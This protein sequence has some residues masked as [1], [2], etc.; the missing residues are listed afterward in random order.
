[1]ATEATTGDAGGNG[2]RPGLPVQPRFPGTEARAGKFPGPSLIPALTAIQRRCGWLPREE[3]V[4]LSRDVRRPLYE[5]EGIISF[6]P[7][8]R[9][10]PPKTV[11]LAVCHDLTCWL[12]GSDE[13]IRETKEKYGDDVEIEIVEVSCLGRCDIA[14]AAAVDERPIALSDADQI[15]ADARGGTHGRTA[16]ERSDE[17]RPNDPYEPGAERYRVF[18]RA[19]AGELAGEDIVQT[20]KDS[21]LRGM[22]GAGFP[23]G[24]KWEMVAAQQAQPKYAICNADESEPGTFKDRQILAEQPHL[25]LEG[26]LLG[27]VVTGCEEGW[28]FIRHEYGPEE[29]VLREEI[30]A[31]RAQG[32]LGED[33][34]GSGRTF[35]IEIFTSPGGYILGEE[36]ALLECMEGHRGEPRNKPP[37]P[38]IYGLWGKPTLMNSVETF[39]SVPII[40]EN[41]ADWWKE[42]GINGATGLKFFAVS[43]H[44]EHPAVYCVKAG[45]TTRDL[46][47]LAGGVT[48]GRAV[49]AFQP[50]GASSNFLGPEHLDV[51]LDWKPLQEAGSMLGSGALTVVAEGTN[52]LAAGTNV[53]RFFR[54]ESC[55]KCV[56]CRV[57]STKAHA[58]MSHL[59]ERGD[60]ISDVP[61]EITQLEETL[62]MTSICGLGQVAMGPLLSVMG[63]DRGGAEARAHPKDPEDTEK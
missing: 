52:L 47:D 2:H 39:A 55:G 6:Y 24:T 4:A 37:F 10:S 43:G 42:Q 27:M 46:I 44:V 35:T 3:L 21:G 53:L 57:G 17:R 25:V 61:D 49:G 33:V 38:A 22:G 59:L 19:L 36:S 30:E 63:M 28:I 8:F 51:P 62:R 15:V 58:I 14:P 50:G 5:I 11:Q 48:E 9:T 54:N 1:M 60:G 34:L 18:R 13:R 41:G 32:I 16:A 45:A 7:H 20:L 29:E 31:M 26:M 40:L 12:H 56:P 23:T